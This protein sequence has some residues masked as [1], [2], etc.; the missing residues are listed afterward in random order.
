VYA[1]LT[2][3]EYQ[4]RHTQTRLFYA[5][6]QQKLASALQ[7]YRIAISHADGVNAWLTLYTHSQS[8]AF[9]LAQ[10]GWLVR[11]GEAFGVSAPSHGLRITLSTL[12]DSEINTLAADV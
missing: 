3:T 1:C 4:H 11:E 12:N 7:Q 2:D 6:R 9:T 10:S 5:F 8:T